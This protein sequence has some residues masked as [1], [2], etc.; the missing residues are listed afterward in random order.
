M[1]N[2][3]EKAFCRKAVSREDLLGELGKK[4]NEPGLRLDDY[5]CVAQGTYC[6]DR[7]LCVELV[8]QAQFPTKWGAFTL[9]GF[10]DNRE[11]KE[12]TAVVQGDVDG[13]EDCPVRTHSECHTGDVWGSLRCDCQAQLEA[14]V[15]YIASKPFGAVVY[16]RQEGRGIGLLNK[17][18]A[19]GLQDQGMDTI[20]ANEHLGFPA[21]A[22]DYKVAAKII[23]ALGIRSVALMTNNPTKIEGLKKEG[24]DIV[25]RIP[26]V[27]PANEHN[28]KYMLTKKERMGHLY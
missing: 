11:G 18:K 15:E 23:E 17:I 22:R 6:R 28:E 26:I 2:T 7:E 4:G 27:V 14:S 24:I 25:R 1:T 12:H 13:A 8:A 5:Y 9:F 19:Y 10:Y 16:L 3:K 21:D 20:E